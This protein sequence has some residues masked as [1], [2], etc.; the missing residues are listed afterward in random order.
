MEWT[1][2]NGSHILH[3]EDWSLNNPIVLAKIIRVRDIM[4]YSLFEA[5]SVT[6]DEMADSGLGDCW[7][8]DS[9]CILGQFVKT[10]SDPS[11]DLMKALAEEQVDKLVK[12]LVRDKLER[13]TKNRRN[14]Q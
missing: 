7:M 2:R 12:L 4:D 9:N 8:L 3:L 14:I 10:S 6:K 11:L 5:Y 1:E 13:G